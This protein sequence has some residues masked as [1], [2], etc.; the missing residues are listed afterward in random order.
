[1]ALLKVRAGRVPVFGGWDVDADFMV[2]GGAVGIFGFCECQL[3]TRNYCMSFFAIELCHVA[4]AT[5]N[6]R[7]VPELSTYVHRK[8]LA[9]CSSIE[10]EPIRSVR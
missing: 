4:I 1:M 10:L 6:A 5:E 3:K 9:R 8:T 2:T 7:A